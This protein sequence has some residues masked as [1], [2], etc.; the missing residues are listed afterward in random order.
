MRSPSALPSSAPQDNSTTRTNDDP[1]YLHQTGALATAVLLLATLLPLGS[2][3]AAPVNLGLD[4]PVT[5]SGHEPNTNFTA[6]RAFDGDPGPAEATDGSVHNH[7]DATRW[8]GVGDPTWLA[9]DFGAPATLDSVRIR[10]GNTFAT[11]YSLQG[12]ADGS[13]WT[14]LATGLAGERASWTTVD[15][16]DTGIS[17]LRVQINTKSTQWPVSIWEVEAMG[18]LEGPVAEPANVAVIPKPVSAIAGTGGSFTLDD[19]TVLAA[20]GEAAG[21]A[22]AFA[23]VA[24]PSTGLPLPVSG[25]AEGNAI[26]FE[27]NTGLNLPGRT[28]EQ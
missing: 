2:A 23:E 3:S 24:R 13:A 28:D 1:S 20:T 14:D 21:A 19:A 27:I 9:V 5:S 15:L 12:S 7:P 25:T 11:D 16:D 8:S 6:E 4:R 10:W 18:S 26:T 22:E 17:R